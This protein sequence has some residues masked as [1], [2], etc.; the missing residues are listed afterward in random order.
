MAALLG[1]GERAVLELADRQHGLVATRQAHACGVSRKAV[2]G[3]V[4]RGLWRRVHRRVLAID[5]RDSSPRA[6]ILAAILTCASPGA[7]A[8]HLSAG[9]LWG[10]LERSPAVV[11]LTALGDRHLG[12]LDGV[13]I[14]RAHDPPAGFRWRHGIPLT[15][16][17]D[18]L[19][20]LAGLLDHDELEAAV[21]K[22][23]RAGLVTRDELAEAIANAGPTKGI[24]ALR[25]AAADPHLTRSGNER[26]LL[27]LLREAELTGYETN[28]VVEGKEVD[29]YWPEAKLAVEADAYATHGDEATYED[30]HV[31]DADFD[32]AD[33]KILRFTGRR[34]RTRPHAVVARIAASLALRLG[35]LPIPRR[36]R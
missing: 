34:I 14:H 15:S 18:T 29:V 13:H 26:A 28:V 36:R 19:L 5:R 4:R 27:A 33:I 16:P 32:A 30:D 25:A 6:G 8:S 35:G 11:H 10:L 17:I 23:L 12:S 21:A 24:A 20:D 9:W 3:R 2:T 31:L 1:P 22:A 7:V